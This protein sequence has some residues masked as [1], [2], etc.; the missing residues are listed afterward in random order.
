MKKA[1]VLLLSA[2]LAAPSLPAFAQ[3]QKAE[4]KQTRAEKRAER[5]AE[6]EHRREERQARRDAKHKKSAPAAE[7]KK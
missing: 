3:E 4:K 5:R 2:V 1:I 6:R 7:E